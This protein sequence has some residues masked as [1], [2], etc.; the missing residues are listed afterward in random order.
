MQITCTVQA[1]PNNALCL[2]NT[3]QV[4]IGELYY[5]KEIRLEVTLH[6][7]SKQD[8]HV[9]NSSHACQLEQ[10]LCMCMRHNNCI[11]MRFFYSDEA[12]GHSKV[13][14]YC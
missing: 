7:Q 6:K 9:R 8:V 4:E 11:Q 3:R 10:Q 1:D 13:C 14:A 5:L 2:M 12:I